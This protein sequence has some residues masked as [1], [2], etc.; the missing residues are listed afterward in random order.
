MCGDSLHQDSIRTD[1]NQCDTPCN[2]DGSEKCGGSYR[3]SL[4]QWNWSNYLGSGGFAARGAVSP[5]SAPRGAKPV[6]G[7]GFTVVTEKP[8]S[9]RRAARK[10]RSAE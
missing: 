9:A 5:S 1:D 6:I 4:Y 3:L 10:E 2:G 7:A 8:S